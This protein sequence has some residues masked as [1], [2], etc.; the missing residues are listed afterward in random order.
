MQNE[1]FV[2]DPSQPEGPLIDA[3]QANA[4]GN[5]MMQG[6]A[7]AVIAG[8]ERREAEQAEQLAKPLQKGAIT[9]VPQDLT[10]TTQRPHPTTTVP[11]MTTTTTTPK[12]T[13]TTTPPSTYRPTTTTTTA[14]STQPEFKD[15]V[16]TL[17]V[18]PN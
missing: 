6:V 18:T 1:N 14:T 2:Q 4:I 17:P 10:I 9:E 8:S 12:S 3:A 7:E 5:S 13:T 11:K 16:T 15:P